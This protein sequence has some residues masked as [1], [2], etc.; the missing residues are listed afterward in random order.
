MV[1]VEA[2]SGFL[3]VDPGGPNIVVRQPRV[4]ARGDGADVG[5]AGW[6]VTEWLASAAENLW[7]LYVFSD[8]FFVLYLRPWGHK[9]RLSSSK[10]TV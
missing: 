1:M 5:P 10:V 8:R 4:S 7:I 3:E 9:A 6:G 2:R